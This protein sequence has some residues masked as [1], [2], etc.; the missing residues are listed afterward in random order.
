MTCVRLLG[1]GR[2]PHRV[3]YGFGGKCGV[4]KANEFTT[5][6]RVWPSQNKATERSAASVTS[7]DDELKGEYLCSPIRLKIG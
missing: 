2:L 7:M 1:L 6:I 3:S 5:E 4:M